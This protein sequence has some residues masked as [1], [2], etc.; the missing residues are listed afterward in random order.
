MLIVKPDDQGIK[1]AAQL[2]RAGKSV[3]YPTDTSYGLAVDATNPVAVK[4]LYR[5]KG[6]NFKKP[7]HVIVSS[8]SMAKKLVVLGRQAEK[9]SKRFLPGPLTVVLPLRVRGRKRG[10]KERSLRL[11][12]AG[13]GTLGIRMSDN[14]IT[15]AL[16]KKLGRPITTTSANISGLPASY[17]PEE[18]LKQFRGRKYQPDLILDAGRLPRVKPSTVVAITGGRVRILRQGPVSKQRIKD[19]LKF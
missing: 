2:L 3:V 12:S 10:L 13:I 5:L 19:A 6:R 11:L 14:K 17:S 1:L 16:V 9:L 7:V 18:V 15:L 4:K 8:L